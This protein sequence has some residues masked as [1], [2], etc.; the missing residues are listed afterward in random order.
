MIW[1][2]FSVVDHF[3]LGHGHNCPTFVYPHTHVSDQVGNV[4]GGLRSVQAL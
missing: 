1:H 4:R 3:S 2:F